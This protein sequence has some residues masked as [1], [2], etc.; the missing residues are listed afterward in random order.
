MSDD[1]FHTTIL[2]FSLLFAL[3]V[4]YAKCASECENFSC[5]AGTEPH[6]VMGRYTSSCACEP[7]GWR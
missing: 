7:E 1:A 2:Y 3:I 5:P 6:F 4:M